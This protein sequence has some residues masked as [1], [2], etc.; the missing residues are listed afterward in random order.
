[1]L[2]PC[3]SLV[4][5]QSQILGDFLY[6]ESLVVKRTRLATDFCASQYSLLLL[7]VNLCYTDSSRRP[8]IFTYKW[9]VVN[10][11]HVSCSFLGESR[12][13]RLG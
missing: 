3:E 2:P 13:V 7:L 9:S 4:Y 11:E 10:V 12:M 8:K 6:L 5:H 1:M